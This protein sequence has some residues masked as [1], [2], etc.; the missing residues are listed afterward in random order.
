MNSGLNLFPREDGIRIEKECEAPNC[1]LSDEQNMTGI[2]VIGKLSI[3][4]LPNMRYLL[5]NFFFFHSLN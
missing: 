1:V 3:V 5:I 2:L 4:T